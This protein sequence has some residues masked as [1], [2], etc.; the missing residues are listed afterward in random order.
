MRG[1]REGVQPVVQPD[2]AHAQAQRLQTVRLRHLREEVPA[3][4]RPPAAPGL[5][6]RQPTGLVTELQLVAGK[7]GN[8][9]VKDPEMCPDVSVR[10]QC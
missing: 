9:A 7:P 8:L 10:F 3:E 1:V 5:S 4:G 2:H 6:A